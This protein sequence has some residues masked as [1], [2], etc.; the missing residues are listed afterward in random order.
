MDTGLRTEIFSF[1]Y[2][3][4]VSIKQ[5]ISQGKNNDGFTPVA[6][7]SGMFRIQNE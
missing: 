1:I 5:S 4:K 3:I 7:C 6:R 2:A